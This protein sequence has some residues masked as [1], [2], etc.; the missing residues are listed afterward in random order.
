[1]TDASRLPLYLMIGVSVLAHGLFL[2]GLPNLPWFSGPPDVF[3]LTRYVV[4]FA[5]PVPT[6]V[7]TVT[8]VAAAE[9]VA[10]E[11]APVEPVPERQVPEPVE[12]VET[13]PA[14]REQR[15]AA[16]KPVVLEPL[17]PKKP[18]TAAP[19]ERVVA[20]TQPDPPRSGAG[21]AGAAAGGRQAAAAPARRSATPAACRRA[22]RPPRKWTCRLR[23]RTT[24]SRSRTPFRPTSA[25]FSKLESHKRYP[26]VAER[27][28]LNGRVVLR[29]TVRRDG[30]VINP[31]V[32]EVTGHDSFRRS[33]LQALTRVG[34]LPP[35][36]ETI[37][38]RDVLVEVPITYRFDDR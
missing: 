21:A 1:M 17:Q 26:R 37:D 5:K 3:R 6:A 38:R 31:E 16:V 12:R 28:G 32:V 4:R 29:F 30:E 34:Q 23:L 2:T 25:S 11:P 15:V 36:P 10:A 8:Q 35:F 9:P 33:A 7:P 13:P 14:V 22:A 19:R 18:R 27:S 20:R 24:G